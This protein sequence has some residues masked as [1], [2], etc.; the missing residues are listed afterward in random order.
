M[1]HI[2]A[3]TA[4]GVAINSLSGAAATNATLAFL[5]GGS[6][7]AGGMGMLGG[8]AVVT[9]GAALIGAAGLLSVVEISK[10]DIQDLNNLVIAGTTGTLA[11]M[12][13]I[14]IA[15]TGASALG[16][17]GTLSGAAAMSATISALGGL[18]VMTGGASL[19]AFGTGFVVWSFLQGQKTRDYNI[20][21][22]LET[23]LYTLT[24]QPDSLSRI[25][26]VN[27]VKDYSQKYQKCSLEDIF[28][29]PEVPLD[30]LENALH[31]YAQ[32]NAEEKIL[33]L[34]DTSL[35]NDAKQGILLTDE[36]VIWKSTWSAPDFIYYSDLLNS[37]K[38]FPSLTDRVCDVRFVYLLTDIGRKFS[39]F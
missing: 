29:A 1:R 5:G 17:A 3:E 31:M 23:R 13:A 28:V 14:F 25:E 2:G 32:V 20:L 16:V 19:I 7:A 11:G 9:G 34:I 27:M 6:V 33:A 39:A 12:A 35:W 8:L 30:R 15:W 36:R 22:Q 37:D 24:N 4:T 38:G 18:S 26:L 10:M 21:H